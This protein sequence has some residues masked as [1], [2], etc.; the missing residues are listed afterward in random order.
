M[1]RNF[2][3]SIMLSVVAFLMPWRAV[4]Q[5][6][7]KEK[8]FASFK[9]RIWRKERSAQVCFEEKHEADGS[10]Y[11]VRVAGFTY[12]RRNMND[13]RIGDEI[14]MEDEL[15]YGCCKAVVTHAPRMALHR[16]SVD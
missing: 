14:A 2:L 12:V 15:N 5:T 16:N 7:A 6:P 9:R 8:P 13:L 11:L 4:A 1:R 10:P 3:K